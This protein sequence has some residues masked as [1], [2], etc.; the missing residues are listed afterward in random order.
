[1][2][3]AMSLIDTASAMPE[4]VVDN[5]FFGL[6][7]TK[8][9]SAMFKGTRER[10]HLAKGETAVSLI[11]RGART[12]GDRLNLDFEKDVDLILTNVSLPDSCFMGCGAS[13]SRVLGTKPKFI[14]DLHNS[15]CVSFVYMLAVAQELMASG[16]VKSALLCC[17]QTSAGRVFAHEENRTRPQSAVPGDGCGVGYIVANDSSPI[18]AVVQRSYG[19]YADDMVGVTDERAEYWEPHRSALHIDFTE[20]KIATVVSRGNKLVPEMVREACKMADVPVKAIDLLVTNQPNVNF[21]RN[22]REALLLPPEKQV[23]TFE[24]HGNLFGAA[25]PVCIERARQTGRLV[26]GNTVAL[27]GF[28]HAGDY[29][30]AALWQ[31]N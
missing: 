17:A 24:E 22:W 3:T 31:P 14:L 15:G 13:V 1:M 5:A 12:L 21:L 4:R 11:E 20:S 19:E 28:S 18:R 26:S 23:H 8:S 6:D 25:I 29:A 9:G 10:R 2:K 7:P 30:A 27:G 16:A